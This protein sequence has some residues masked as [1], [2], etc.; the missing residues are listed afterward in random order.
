MSKPKWSMA[1]DR[2]LIVLSKTKS[3]DAI[4]DQ[5]GRSPKFIIKKAM[6]LGLNIKGRTK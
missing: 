6:K 5:L 3:L 4:A 2:E 1:D